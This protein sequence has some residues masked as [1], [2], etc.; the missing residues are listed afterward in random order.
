ME[1]IL[2]A[3][4]AAV[5]VIGVIIGLCFLSAYP[6]MWL[7]NYTFTPTVLTSLFGISALTFWK[8]FWL[9]FLCCILFKGTTT[10][11]SK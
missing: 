10:T 2:K 11:T 4:G 5:L 9:N 6:T 3:V 7:M 1:T 8:A